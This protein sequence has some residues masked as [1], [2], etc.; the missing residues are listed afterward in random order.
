MVESEV[1]AEKIE[2]WKNQPGHVLT[3]GAKN[4]LI[5]AALG[6]IAG[7]GT[8][9]VS[10][11][12][13]YRG[14]AEKLIFLPAGP[15]EKCLYENRTIYVGEWANQRMAEDDQLEEVLWKF[16]VDFEAVRSIALGVEADMVD[17]LVDLLRDDSPVES[18]LM[19][20]GDVPLPA[21]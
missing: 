18:S 2:A 13:C 8:S 6:R 10:F 1:M 12:L 3:D 20:K 7:I 14:G 19:D 11:R 9:I 5:A 4:L 15:E 21:A 17:A 16:W